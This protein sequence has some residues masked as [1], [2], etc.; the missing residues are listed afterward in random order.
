M[1]RGNDSKQ[2]FRDLAKKN[3]KFICRMRKKRLVVLKNTGK[4]TK[5]SK[6]KPGKYAIYLLDHHNNKVKTDITYT[7]IINKHLENKEEIRLISNLPFDKYSEDEFVKKYL[8]RWG[9]EKSFRR[10]KTKFFIAKITY[11]KCGLIYHFSCTKSAYI[12][13]SKSP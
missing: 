7:L 3:I 9:V 11:Q 5:L 8:E 13:K 1:D 2:F 6:L 4:I 10:I 12:R